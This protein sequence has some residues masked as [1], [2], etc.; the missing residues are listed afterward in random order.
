MIGGGAN[1][2]HRDAPGPGRLTDRG[3]M[4]G[5]RNLRKRLSWLCAFLLVLAVFPIKANGFGF[6]IQPY[7]QDV[8]QTSAR[9]LGRGQDRN[10]GGLNTA[11]RQPMVLRRRAELNGYG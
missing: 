11:Q 8:Q 4:D 3:N 2:P 5:V 9:V 10:R 6:E 1:V 7:V